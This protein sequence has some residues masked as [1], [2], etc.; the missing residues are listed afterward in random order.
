M[1]PAKSTERVIA[2]ARVVVVGSINMDA[3]VRAG[4]LPVP[5]ETVT[6]TSFGYFPGGKGAN[7]AVAASL[8]GADALMVGCIGDD[9]SGVA[10]RAF[11]D[12][13]GV[14]ASHVRM[15]SAETSGTAV[16]VVDDTGEN[17][18]VIVAGANDQVTVD[19][20][21][22]VD[23]CRGDVL[24]TQFEIPTAAVFAA[25]RRARDR[26]AIAVLN[27]APAIP[28]PPEIFSLA[29]VIV[30]NETELSMISGLALSVDATD[31]E[32]APA[33][34]SLSRLRPEGVTILTTGARGGTVRSGSSTYS[35]AGRRVQAADSTG[36]GDCF[37]GTLAARL[38]MCDELEK[39]VLYA[40]AAASIC[41][42][43]SGAGPSMPVHA[44]VL[45]AL[46]SDSA[47][48][49]RS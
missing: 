9:Q 38:A 41:V 46:E 1:W 6:G 26:G 25:L 42:Q 27:P 23:V 16:I 37:V 12:S 22:G 10:L 21:A 29:D 30:L 2:V 19:D 24:L 8:V 14:D 20:V 31:R 13:N 35:F 49:V 36:A 45:A 3:V 33:L 7:E 15:V 32:I 11:L 39:A 40:N 17:Q 18:I 43:R 28:V 47:A 4:R 34:D 5:G 44:E 48:L